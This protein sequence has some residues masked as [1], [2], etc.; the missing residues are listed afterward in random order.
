[1]M[2]SSYLAVG[3]ASWSHIS[4]NI[5]RILLECNAIEAKSGTV[6]Q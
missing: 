6:K 2:N 3:G 4:P 1:M 5:T